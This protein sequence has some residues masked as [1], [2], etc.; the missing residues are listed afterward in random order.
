[1]NRSRSTLPPNGIADTGSSSNNDHCLKYLAEADPHEIKTRIEE[2]KGGLLKVA[3]SWILHHANFQQW[4]NGDSQLLWIKGD[5]DK[6]KI[7][8]L[9][10]II[11]ELAGKTKLRDPGATT[12]LSYFCHATDASLNNATAVLRGLIPIRS[13]AWPYSQRHIPIEGETAKQKI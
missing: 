4:R 13:E 9:C 10:T 7:M 5:P 3:S 6:G 2:T 8:L 1:M 11:D 12:L